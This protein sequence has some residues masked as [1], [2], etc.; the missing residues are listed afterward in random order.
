MLR[1]QLA[2]RAR[3]TAERFSIR[4]SARRME[5]IYLQLMEESGRRR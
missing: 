1:Q 5:E 3:C 2:A 4:A